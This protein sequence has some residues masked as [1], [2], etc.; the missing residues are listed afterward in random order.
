[1][2]VKIANLVDCL[3]SRYTT[4]LAINPRQMDFIVS[5]PGFFGT[6]LSVLSSEQRLQRRRG[7][8]AA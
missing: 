6:L 3:V 1:M 2:C 7:R 5:V 4:F 8:S